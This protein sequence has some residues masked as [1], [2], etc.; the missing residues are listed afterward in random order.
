MLTDGTNYYLVK[1]KEEFTDYETGKTKKEVKQKLVKAISVSDSE[2]KVT[3]L[4]KGI[5]WDWSIIS[6]SESKIDEVI[7]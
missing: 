4:Y 5:T 7:N 1:I 6:S 3:E 2:T